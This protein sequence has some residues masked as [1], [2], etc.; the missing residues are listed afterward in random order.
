MNAEDAAWGTEA[1]MGTLSGD[2]PHKAAARSS[3]RCHPCFVIPLEWGDSAP[4]D[5]AEDGEA[6]FIHPRAHPSEPA[7]VTRRSPSQTAP[8]ARSPPRPGPLTTWP[9]AA[10]TY[11][12]AGASG[13]A[14]GRGPDPRGA[15]GAL[16]RLGRAA[17]GD[18]EVWGQHDVTGGR[19]RG[20]A[21][22]CPDL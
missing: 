3:F 20:A 9:P 5:A 13:S 11:V 10:V 18:R 16:P 2:H 8:G 12:E 19:R 7:A 17:V 1:E 4:K 22:T 14:A 21:A 6:V 15:G